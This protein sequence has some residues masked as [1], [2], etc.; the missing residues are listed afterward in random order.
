[1]PA[2]GIHLLL[3]TA[4]AY[5]AHRRLA[6]DRPGPERLTG[7][8]LVVA[9]GGA[10]WAWARSSP[11]CSSTGWSSTRWPSRPRWRWAWAGASGGLA[12]ATDGWAT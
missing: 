1:M 9:L 12:T 11:G 7:F 3:F 2:I 8:F 4:G 5:V 10:R 6:L